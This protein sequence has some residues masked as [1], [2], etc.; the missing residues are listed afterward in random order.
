M[1]KYRVKWHYA[2]DLTNKEQTYIVECGNENM[3]EDATKMHMGHLMGHKMEDV[4]ID[5]M[6]WV[7]VEPAPK[8]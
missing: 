8:F 7:P 3:A 2:F 6:C 5:G 1:R 4:V